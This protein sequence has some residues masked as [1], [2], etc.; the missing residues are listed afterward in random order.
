MKVASLIAGLVLAAVVAAEAPAASPAGSLVSMVKD[1]GN[2]SRFKM[3]FQGSSSDMHVGLIKVD[4]TVGKVVLE[5]YA[6]AGITE[7]MWQQFIVSMKAD[8]PQIEAGYVQVGSRS[9]MV[10][11]SEYLAGAESLD[12][13]MFLLTEAEL[14]EGKQKNI[15]RVGQEKLTTP[16][17]TVTCSRYQVERPDQKLEFWIS[18]E[19]RPIG[20]VKMVSTGKKTEQNYRLELEELLSGVVAKIN[21]AK[22]VPL[23]DAVKKMISAPTK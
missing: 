2:G 12:V 13:S 17:G 21:P 9:P 10:L 16:A 18:D 7:P 15:Q 4:P 1:Q 6:K 20:L 3:H 22:A 19:A 23:T 14:R 11:T 8:R 5:V